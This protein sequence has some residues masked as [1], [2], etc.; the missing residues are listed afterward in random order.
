MHDI[1]P[2]TMT[3]VYGPWGRGTCRM[4]TTDAENYCL[5]AEELGPRRRIR[6]RG[7]TLA[8]ERLPAGKIN[9][10]AVIVPGR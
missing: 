3:A 9:G 10:R 4:C 2:G 7:S 1:E 5:R 6:A 8:Y